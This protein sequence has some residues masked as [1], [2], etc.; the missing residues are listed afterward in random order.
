MWHRWSSRKLNVRYIKWE[1]FFPSLFV[2]GSRHLKTCLKTAYISVL[3]RCPL[4][5]NFINNDEKCSNRK[6]IQTHSKLHS[7]LAVLIVIDMMD[8]IHFRLLRHRGFILWVLWVMCWPRVLRSL[9]QKHSQKKKKKSCFEA[10]VCTQ[11]VC[12]WGRQTWMGWTLS[13]S[14]CMWI[15]QQS[16]SKVDAVFVVPMVPLGDTALI[17]R[18]QN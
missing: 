16:W 13:T 8:C 11:Q 14:Y 10:T 12:A 2:F 17:Y 6:W 3:W 18:E 9:Q 7:R 1:L 4:L 15:L 5:T